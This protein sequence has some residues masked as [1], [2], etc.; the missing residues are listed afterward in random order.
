MID[1]SHKSP[2]AK[3]SPSNYCEALGRPCR[4]KACDFGCKLLR[5]RARHPAGLPAAPAMVDVAVPEAPENTILPLQ[6]E[7]AVLEPA[8]ASPATDP[9][10]MVGDP[11]KKRRARRSSETP[12]D[13]S[14]LASGNHLS[15]LKAALVGLEQVD[16]IMSMSAR[17]LGV[18]PTGTA[19]DGM[20]ETKRRLAALIAEVSRLN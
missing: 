17:M 5:E 20:R 10:P 16:V 7:P 4:S 19:L 9:L 18:A 8:I 14:S 12:I 13:P 6:D 3:A 11:T 1:A 15:V 2:K